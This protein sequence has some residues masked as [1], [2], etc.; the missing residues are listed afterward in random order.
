MSHSLAAERVQL[1]LLPLVTRF[2]TL[3]ANSYAALRAAKGE[4]CVL[5]CG[6]PASH[7]PIR[8]Q[9]SAA[10]VARGCR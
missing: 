6:V 1:C 9:F 4:P 8:T 3:V 5:A 10:A 2:L 7:S